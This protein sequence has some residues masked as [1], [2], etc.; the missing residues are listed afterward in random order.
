[1]EDMVNY[2]PKLKRGGIMSGHDFKYADEVPG[3]DWSVCQ[4]GSK[5]PGA[6]RGAVEEFCRKHY[7]Q[8]GVTYREGDWNTWYFRKP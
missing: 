2:W 7:L 6:V 4:D 3:Q 5:H 8:P 1:M